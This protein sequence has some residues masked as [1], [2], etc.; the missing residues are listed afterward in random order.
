MMVAT[1]SMAKRKFEHDLVRKPI[2]TFRDHAR[3]RKVVSNTKT[4]VVLDDK[5]LPEGF[6]Q[7]VKD[8]QTIK[9][10]SPEAG[11]LLIALNRPDKLNA[12]DEHMIREIRSVIWKANF[13]DAVRVVII[14]GNGRAFCAGRD[15]KGLDFENNLETAGYRAYVRANHEM[16]DDFENIE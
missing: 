9:V 7:H 16:W 8:F 6:V 3:R 5:G 12:F 11:I 4:P 1:H 10:S 2:P 15:I 14:T 13:D